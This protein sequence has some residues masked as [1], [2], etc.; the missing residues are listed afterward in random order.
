MV[1]VAL[2]VLP[3]LLHKVLNLL[4]RKR[5]LAHEYAFPED[6]GRLAQSEAVSAMR[7]SK[8]E[9]S[10]AQHC[11]WCMQPVPSLDA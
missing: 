6:C 8:Y 1:L 5:G 9:V 7:S 4:R 2:V 10:A 11:A 3:H